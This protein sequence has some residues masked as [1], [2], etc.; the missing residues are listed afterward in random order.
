MLKYL[1]MFNICLSSLSIHAKPTIILIWKRMQTKL[2]EVHSNYTFHKY[3]NIVTKHLRLAG[4]IKK[5]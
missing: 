4:Q 2:N 1:Q 3:S 5:W